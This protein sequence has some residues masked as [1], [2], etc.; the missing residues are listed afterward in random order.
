MTFQLSCFFFADA[1]LDFSGKALFTI[2]LLVKHQEWSLISATND[3]RNSGGPTV[4][5][6]SKLCTAL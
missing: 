2:K 6:H 4:R 5:C 1:R 3:Q